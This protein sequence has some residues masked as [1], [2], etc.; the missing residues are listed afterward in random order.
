MTKLWSRVSF[1]HGLLLNSQLILLPWGFG[2]DL[3]NN[4]DDLTRVCLFS[5]IV[6]DFLRI[7]HPVLQ[8]ANLGHD[9]LK[10]VHNKEYEVVF[11]VI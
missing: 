8:M 11:I 2:Y 4:I 3:P 10:A 9:A 6:S 7:F 5:H 1:P